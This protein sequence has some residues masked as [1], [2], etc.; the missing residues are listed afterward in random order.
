M[1]R[2]DG[3]RAALAAVPGEVAAEF[4]GNAEW[5]TL[6][7]ILPSAR[8]RN[9]AGSGRYVRLRRALSRAAW[10]VR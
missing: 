8:L 5:L 6:R 1:G 7:R 3:R 4:G 9:P 2:F 10:R